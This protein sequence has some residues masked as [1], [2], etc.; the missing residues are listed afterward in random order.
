MGKVLKVMPVVLIMVLAVSLI[1]AFWILPNHLAHSLAHHNP[2]QKGQFRQRFDGFIE[3]LRENAL[4][5]MV[6]VAIRWRYLVV[7]IHGCGFHHFG[8][9]AG[10]R[11]PEIQSPFP[12]SM[13][14]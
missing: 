9:Y 8:G 12:T 4:G 13:G 5:R 11:N 14:M 3:G 7:G 2:D 1:E 6:D 10:C